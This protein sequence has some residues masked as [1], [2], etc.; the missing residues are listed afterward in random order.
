LTTISLKSLLDSDTD[1]N[2]NY[3]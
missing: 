2:I 1:L 3:S